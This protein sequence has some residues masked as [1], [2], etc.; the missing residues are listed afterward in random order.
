MLL[1]LSGVKRPKMILSILVTI[2]ETAPV[3]TGER[4]CRRRST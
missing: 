4:H 2:V 1:T 3:E